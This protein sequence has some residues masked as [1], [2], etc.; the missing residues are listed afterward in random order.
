MWVAGY[1]TSTR[2]RY[3]FAE[4]LVGDLVGALAAALAVALA[5]AL[6]AAFKIAGWPEAVF[7]VVALAGEALTAGAFTGALATVF[8][9]AFTAA[10]AGVLTGALAEAFT[11]A[12]AAVRATG[13]ATLAVA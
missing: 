8:A 9:G 2:Q 1:G 11:V 12:L 3:F 6:G 10:L 4:A 5:G 7:V 13:A